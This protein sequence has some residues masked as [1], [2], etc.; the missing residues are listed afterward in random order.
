MPTNPKPQ[1]TPA[2][3]PP[4]DDT[5]EFAE[6][7]APDPAAGGDQSG[8]PGQQPGRKALLAAGGVACAL[9]AGVRFRRQRAAR[10][11]R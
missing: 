10:R 1:T 4:E 6:P 2:T 3:P 5:M 7:V 8:R 11:S 9:A